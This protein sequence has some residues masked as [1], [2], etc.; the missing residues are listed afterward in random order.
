MSSKGRIEDHYELF[1]STELTSVQ[2][3]Q[4]R[5]PRELELFRDNFNLLAQ[6]ITDLADELGDENNPHWERD[7]SIDRLGA[8]D[9]EHGRAWRTLVAEDDLR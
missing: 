9:D 7:R 5:F 4:K 3:I 6:T 1:E 8:L 2:T